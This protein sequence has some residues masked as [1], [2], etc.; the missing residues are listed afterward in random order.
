MPMSQSVA[1]V[2]AAQGGLAPHWAGGFK[3]KDDWCRKTGTNLSWLPATPCCFQAAGREAF[4][5]FFSPR[6]IKRR[7]FRNTYKSRFSEQSQEHQLSSLECVLILCDENFMLLNKNAK[8]V[9][10]KAQTNAVTTNLLINVIWI[11]Q[12]PCCDIR[13]SA[14]LLWR[15]CCRWL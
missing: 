8:L 13:L 11:L 12:S 1:A 7:F 2:L 10:Q 5:H 14:W 4:S 3:F 15:Q 9:Q 6:K